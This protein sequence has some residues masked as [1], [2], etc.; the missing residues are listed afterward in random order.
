MVI[1]KKSFFQIFLPL[2]IIGFIGQGSTLV[3][4]LFSSNS[5]WILLFVLFCYL[6]MNGKLLKGFYN[7]LLTA[8]LLYL[9]WCLLT[10]LWSEVFILSCAKTGLLLLVSITM[11]SAGFEWARRYPWENSLNWLF[12]L[13]T[14]AFLSG[15]LGKSVGDST[16]KLDNIDV[17]KGLTGNS[18]L[19]GIFQ[20]MIFPCL[21]WGLYKNWESQGRRLIWGG[22]LGV[23]LLFL[24]LSYSRSAI[25]MMLCTAFFFFLSLNVK[26]KLLMMSLLSILVSLVFFLTSL[27]I[28]N[29]IF[30]GQS[31]KLLNSRESVWLKSYEQAKLGGWMGG[32]YGVTIGNNQFEMDGLSAAEYGREKSSSQLG[33]ME[34]TGIIGFGFY[35][36]FL[37]VYFTRLSQ[38]YRKVRGK[39][40]V[41]VG[42]ILGTLLGI[43]VQSIFEA[44]WDAPG[45]PEAFYFWTLF[46]TSIGLMRTLKRT[47]SNYGYVGLETSY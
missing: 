1:R 41:L 9:S 24:T 17:Y 14:I 35:L 13:I 20:S 5:R 28:N 37:F 6:F 44:W 29:L 7:E 39:E 30:K 31:N 26:K 3:N 38:F 34:E 40:K 43:V 47:S 21:L 42:I 46:G 16:Y 27:S 15:I 4:F 10:V 2:V 19:F 36:L 8:F 33:I 23:C 11:A 25:L 22:F 45:S 18:N 32:G 12:L